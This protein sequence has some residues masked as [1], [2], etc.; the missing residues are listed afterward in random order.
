[1]IQ[2]KYNVT[3]DIDSKLFVVVVSEPTKA[4][5][6]EIANI[7]EKHSEKLTHR[8][9]LQAELNEAQ[10]EFDINKQI[11]EFGTV[12]EKSKVWL[13]QKGLNKQ[14]H[15]LKKE[16]NEIDKGLIDVNKMIEEM[17]AKR[18]EMVVSGADKIS[19]QKEIE[20]KDIEY[21]IIFNAMAELIKEEKE[22][23]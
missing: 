2:T 16:L 19:L 5:K 20:A 21:R 12:V 9:S 4:Q 1:M 23:K 6:Q 3:L 15:K 8:D 22:K 7:S 18:F 13:P 17:L 14:I 11:L 10:E